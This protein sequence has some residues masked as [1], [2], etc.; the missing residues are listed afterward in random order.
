MLSEA[1]QNLIDALRQEQKG[2]ASQG[3]LT[4]KE[5][6]AQIMLGTPEA[7]EQIGRFLGP[8]SLTVG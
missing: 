7:T 8:G 4:P 3:L 2:G 1:M 6:R 5:R